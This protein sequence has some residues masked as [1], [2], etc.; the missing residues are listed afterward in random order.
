MLSNRQFLI[1]KALNSLSPRL[2][3]FTIPVGKEGFTNPFFKL[4]DS[5]DKNAEIP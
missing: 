5:P 1:L 3:F 4:L 2:S